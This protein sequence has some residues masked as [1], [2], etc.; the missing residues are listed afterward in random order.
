MSE[1]EKSTEIE[2]VLSS[3]RRLVAE[4]PHVISETSHPT[5]NVGQ[6][7]EEPKQVA[8]AEE[9][10][11]NP[12]RTGFVETMNASIAEITHDSQIE[13][14]AVADAEAQAAQLD[15]FFKTEAETQAQNTT[16]VEVV[17][18]KPE[19]FVLRPEMSADIEPKKT[20]TTVDD[21]VNKAEKVSDTEDATQTESTAVFEEISPD[22]VEEIVMPEN[23]EDDEIALENEHGAQNDQATDQF[24][25]EEALREIVSEMVRAELQGDLGDRI[26]RNVRKLV[27]REIHHALATR[28]FE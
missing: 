2:D 20:E 7:S 13:E 17:L 28:D 1:A 14:T 24:V 18:E 26:T 10:E 4:R 25:D 23:A 19:P 11:N 21:I 6:T 9:S 12:E 3:I 5:D 15:A 22:T 27:R 16:P 8:K